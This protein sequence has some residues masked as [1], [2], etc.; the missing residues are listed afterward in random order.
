MTEPISPP[1]QAATATAGAPSQVLF[2][3]F[4]EQQTSRRRWALLLMLPLAGVGVWALAHETAKI[5][6]V[7]TPHGI[8]GVTDGMSPQEVLG[9]LGKP[10]SM[11]RG[12]DGAD[13]YMYGRPTL[14]KAEFS[15]YSVC[16]ADG[17]MRD[18]SVRR[19][20]SWRVGPNGTFVPS[21]D[22]A[23]GPAPETPPAAASEAAPSAAPEG[24]AK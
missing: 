15:V 1:P 21:E 6:P 18:I 5:K 7:V 14:A 20:A 9:V 13:C 16:Y 24:A 19:F 12:A 17:K 3:A 2:R 23:P 10:I 8:R 11:Q 4:K 22:A